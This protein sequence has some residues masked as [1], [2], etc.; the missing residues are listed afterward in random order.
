MATVSALISTYNRCEYVAGAIDTVLNQTY[1]DIEAIVVDDC[2]T[3]QTPELLKQYEEY[4]RVRTVRNE[5]NSGIAAS[6]NRA[7]ELADGEYLCILDD[8]DRWQFTMSE[9]SDKPS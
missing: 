5:E 2:S 7:A 8:D 6:H 1:D 4:D 9:P 3:D